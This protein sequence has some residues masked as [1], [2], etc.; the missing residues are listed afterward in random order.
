MQLKP[1]IERKERRSKDK[2]KKEWKLKKL[3]TRNNKVHRRKKTK[4]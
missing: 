2:F 1:K 3:E 4:K